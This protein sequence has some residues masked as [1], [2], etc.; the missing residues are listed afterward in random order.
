MVKGSPINSKF[1]SLK[2]YQNKSF[3]TDLRALSSKII[4]LPS[5][6]CI[7]AGH[8]SLSSPQ[9]GLARENYQNFLP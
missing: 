5:W 2:G 4:N 3:P 9:G 6:R 8:K 7:S 1:Q